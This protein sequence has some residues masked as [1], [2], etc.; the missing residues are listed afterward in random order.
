MGFEVRGPTVAQSVL[1]IGQQVKAFTV[2]TFEEVLSEEVQKG[3][4]N[5][6]I[7]QTDGWIGRDPHDVRNFGRIEARSRAQL[8]SVVVWLIAELERLSPQGG[9]RDP[10]PG[11]YRNSHFVMVDGQWLEDAD[12]KADLTGKRVMVVN[13]QPYAGKI[14]GKD[15]YT[16]HEMRGGKNSKRAKRRAQGWKAADMRGQSKQAPLGVYRVALR[17]LQK[18]YGKAVVALYQPQQLSGAIKVMTASGKRRAQIYPAIVL[19]I[20]R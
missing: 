20:F 5:A 13:T 17:N 15:A 8:G 16:R 11:L 3:F 10:H 1:S 19:S 14:E 4:D 7:V 18:R 6:P 12:L 9:R 2:R